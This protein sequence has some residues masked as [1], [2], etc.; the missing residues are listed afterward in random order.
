MHSQKLIEN[1]FLVTDEFENFQ[2]NTYR[3]MSR[4]YDM[5]MFLRDGLKTDP[6]LKLECILKQEVALE[7]KQLT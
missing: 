2:A 7:L 6:T 5:V 4:V 3:E 1:P